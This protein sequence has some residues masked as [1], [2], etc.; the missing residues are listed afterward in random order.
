[1]FVLPVCMEM[2]KDEICNVS[3]IYSC[4][5]DVVKLHF[6]FWSH[7]QKLCFCES[8]SSLLSCSLFFLFLSFPHLGFFCPLLIYRLSFSWNYG[9]LTFQERRKF[10]PERVAVVENEIGSGF[11]PPNAKGFFMS[12]SRRIGQNFQN[13]VSVQRCILP[14][15]AAYQFIS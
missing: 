3:G 12:N 9:G 13:K 15:F 4:K 8:I 2:A 11:F 10:Y 14:G 7:D 1:M 6:L 5:V